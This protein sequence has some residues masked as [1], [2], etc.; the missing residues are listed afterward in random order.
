MQQM[1][2]ELSLNDI[3]NGYRVINHRSD[4]LVN[5]HEVAQLDLL[6]TN[7]EPHDTESRTLQTHLAYSGCIQ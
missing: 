6:P 5:G 4:H 2:R 7:N 3:I 1:Q